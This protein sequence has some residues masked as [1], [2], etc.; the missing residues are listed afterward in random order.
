MPSDNVTDAIDN[1]S[2]VMGGFVTPVESIGSA[3]A[4]LVAALQLIRLFE[5]VLLF[6]FLTLAFW[7]NDTIL[8]TVSGIITVLLG[9][10]WI[11]TYPGISVTLWGFAVYQLTFK[12][13]IPM[14]YSGGPERGLS[15]FKALISRAR[16]R[17]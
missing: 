8:F 6:G 17:G 15:Q 4:L 14:L 12:A 1:L 13:L 2:T 16:G 10:E 3:L 5:I 11:D 9:T 7:K